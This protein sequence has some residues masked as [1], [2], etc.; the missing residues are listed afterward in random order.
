MIRKLKK[1]DRNA[2]LEIW[3]NEN[4]RAHSFISKE[5]WKNAYEFVKEILPNAEVYVFLQNEVIL[6]FIGL[7]GELIEGIFVAENYQGRGIGKDLLNYVKENR[8]SLILQVYQKNTKAICFYEKNG[9][10]VIKE[11]LD[12]HTNEKEYTMCWKKKR[13]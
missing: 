8:D 9:F 12:Y 2:V 7:N 4:T 13:S 6:G 10:E 5:Y 3:L 1:D 11:G